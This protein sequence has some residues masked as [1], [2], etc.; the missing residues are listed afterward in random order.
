MKASIEF[1]KAIGHSER[2]YVRC[3]SPKN[4]PLPELES[5]GMTYTDKSGKVRNS[6]VNGYIDL[7]TGEFYRRYGKDY[8][9][10]TDG[11]GHL[12]ELNQQGYGVYFVVGHGGVKNDDITHGS[13]LFHESD[14]ATL[15]QQQL[16]IDR[17]TQEF[18][19]P[20]AVVKTR[21]SLHGYWASAETIPVENLATHQR[22]W[23]QFSNCDDTSLDDPAQLMRLPGFDHLAWNSKTNDFDRVQCELLQLNEVSYSLAEF[24]RILPALDVD[25]YC[26][27]SLELVESDADDRDMRSIAQYL[28]GFDSS[29]KWIK[30]KCPAHDGESSDSLHIDSETGGFICHAGCS[31]SA[32]YNATK[33]VAVA[34]GH[35]FEVKQEDPELTQNISDALKMKACKAPN[36]FGGNMGKQLREAADNFNIPTRILEFIALPVLASRID[37]RTKLVINPG[38]DFTV[39]AVRWCGLVGETGTMKSPVIK[40]LIKPMSKHQHEIAEIYKE[41]RQE[42]DLAHSAWKANKSQDKGDEPLAP[43]PMLDLYFSNFTIEAIV[44]AI[45]HYMDK[46]YLIF[47]DELAQFIKS[48]DMY[49]GGKGADRQKWLTIWDAGGI[50][51]NRKSSGSVFIPQVSISIIGG[52][53]PQTIRNMISGDDS[54]LDGLWHRFSYVELPE[55]TIEPF[56]ELTGD[57]TDELDKIYRALSEQAQQTYWLSLDAKPLWAEWHYEM[58]SKRM[59]VTQ[60]MLKGVYPKFHGICGRNALIL[61]C[62][63]AAIAGTVPDQLITASTV[64]TAIAWTRWELS[65]TL[66][67][68]QKLGLTD[69]PELAKILKFI[70]RFTGKGWVSPSDARAWWSTKPKP[71]FDELKS[72]MAKVVSLG[73]AIDNDEPIASSKYRIQ[74][75]E[76]SSQ[77]SH[78]YPENHTQHTIQERLLVVTDSK[79]GI[80][81]MGLDGG[82]NVVTTDSHESSHSYPESIEKG[83][84]DEHEKSVTTNGHESSH[85][86]EPTVNGHYSD[87]SL[88]SV[89]I[90]SHSINA[91]SSNSSSDVVTTLTTFHKNNL[92]IGDRA[93]LGDEIFIIDRIEDDFIGGHAIDGSYIGGHIS[94]VQLVSVDEIPIAIG[95]TSATSN[96]YTKKETGDGFIEIVSNRSQSSQNT[97]VTI[98]EATEDDG[99]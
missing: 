68:Y 10:V 6:T 49:R 65:Q 76:K 85:N 18:G 9:P 51:N 60:E 82:L 36:L 15:E 83:I 17:I 3:L 26:Q 86:P 87:S 29:G 19:K 27:L 53:Q 62:T 55:T 46:G 66:I 75:L 35:R 11:W 72:F 4:I 91:M 2:F 74:I 21:K 73:Y 50:K 25:R 98:P 67:Q 63:Y 58:Q 77:S 78:I 30:A 14:K 59:S 89:T 96:G 7:Q 32:V 12:L 48:L 13:T 1:L 69:D 47:N 90:G 42:Y 93:K 64:E 80:A 31:S 54:N 28:P 24:D 20:T 39:P 70:D 92:K 44:D 33:A 99:Y 79:N 97:D 57:L 40:R 38:T 88:E 84:S 34:A 5:R 56:T 61:H 22:R 71:S 16:E 41:V 81:Q 95:R 43:P 8:K 37:S 45:Q 94:S 52:I 23:L